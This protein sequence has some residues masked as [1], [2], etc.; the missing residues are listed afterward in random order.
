MPRTKG[1]KNKATPTAGKVIKT[2]APRME[3]TSD[4]QQFYDAVADNW[5]LDLVSERLLRLAAEA[6]SDSQKLEAVMGDQKTY[7]DRFGVERCSELQ[8]FSS[9]ARTTAINCLSKLQQNLGE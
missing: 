6:I 1:A 2:D 8:K 9:A 7:I 3:L 5:R 4:G